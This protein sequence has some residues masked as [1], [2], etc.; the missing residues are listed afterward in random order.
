M[1][2]PDKDYKISRILPF[3]YA[4]NLFENNELFFSR[5][6]SWD[7][8]YEKLNDYSNDRCTRIILAQCWCMTG[9]SDAMWR[10]F[11]QR[12]DLKNYGPGIQI[13][14]YVSELKESI[15][16]VKDKYDFKLH[17]RDVNYLSIK[18]YKKMIDS[19]S[20]ISRAF[21]KRRAFQHELEYRFLITSNSSNKKIEWCKNGAKIKLNIKLNEIIHNVYVDPFASPHLVEAIQE[22]FLKKFNIKCSQSSIYKEPR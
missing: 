17:N 7:D 5:P 3:E 19:K 1:E 2:K 20:K 11:T 18:N 16:D 14:T 22:Y 13:R 10:I 21:I 6:S 8:P 12:K 15:N 4:V 9:Y